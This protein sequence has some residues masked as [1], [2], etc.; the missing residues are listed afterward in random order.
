M[1]AYLTPNRLLIKF[2]KYTHCLT[3]LYI[4]EVLEKGLETRTHARVSLLE[5]LFS[6]TEGYVRDN[7]LFL[8][9]S[10]ICIFQNQ[11]TRFVRVQLE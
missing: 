10:E 11:L 6:I 1:N 2:R 9:I 8:F 5:I 7:T 4:I 3:E